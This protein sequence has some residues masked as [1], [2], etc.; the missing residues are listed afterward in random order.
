MKRLLFLAALALA[1]AAQASSDTMKRFVNP[2]YVFEED[3]VWEEAS[4]E[5]PAYPTQANWV[6]FFVPLDQT[7]D[8]SIDANTLALGSDG[9]LRMTVRAVS[10]KGAVNLSYEGLR[11]DARTLRVYAFGDTINHRWIESRKSAW[12][13]LTPDDTVRVRLRS[14][15]CPDGQV[16]SSTERALELLKK[17]PW[18]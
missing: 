9:V 1:S 4:Y 11:C 5:L 2:N 14:D 3:K 12:R 17:S 16:P 8:Y 13:R 15:M 6:G 18:L 7:F 10:K